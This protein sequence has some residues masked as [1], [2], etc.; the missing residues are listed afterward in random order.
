MKMIVQQTRRKQSNN[1]DNNVH[2]DDD[3]RKF[4]FQGRISHFSISDLS[5]TWNSALTRSD[6]VR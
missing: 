2:H 5:A 3:G 1:D 6:P 4:S